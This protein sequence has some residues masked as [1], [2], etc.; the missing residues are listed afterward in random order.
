MG[1]D[2][3]AFCFCQCLPHFNGIIDDFIERQV[4]FRQFVHGFD[5]RQTKQTVEGGNQ[6]V[7]FRDGGVD[8][9]HGVFIVCGK[10]C[11]LES[12]FQAHQWGTQIMGDG[13]GRRLDATHQHMDAIEHTIQRLAQS[14]ETVVAYAIGNTFVQLPRGK[15]M[16]GIQRC[17]ECVIQFTS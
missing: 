5:T 7:R 17:F 8:V 6:L 15:T 9:L 13:I 3:L 14:C 1:I 2:G 10:P 4:F 11:L 12:R 16:H